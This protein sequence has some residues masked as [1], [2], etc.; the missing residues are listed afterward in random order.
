[1]GGGGRRPGGSGAEGRV[2]TGGGE[3][4]GPGLGRVAWGR[5]REPGGAADPAR[6][7]G[8]ADGAGR[9][10]DGAGRERGLRAGRYTA[11]RV[12]PNASNQAESSS[13]TCSM[14]SAA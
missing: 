7:R 14:P 12:R 5:G 3:A 2:P 11:V 6:L 1:G 10:A 9:R 8:R 4:G 13:N